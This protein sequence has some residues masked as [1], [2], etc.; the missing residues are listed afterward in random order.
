[1]TAVTSPAAVSSDAAVP[2][3][4]ALEDAVRTVRFLSID[5]VEKAESGHPGAPMGLAGIA[6]EF[7]ARQLNHLP[8]DPQWPN[9]DRFVLSCGHASMLLYS[10]LH[11]S[12]YDV[13]VDDL[14]NFR[15]WGSK[16][17][18][19]PE[20][21]HTPGVETTTGPLGQGIGNAVGLALAQKM[22]SARLGA[23]SSLLDYSV[24][25]VCSDGD[26]MEGVAYE[27]A[28]LAGHLKLDN[29][30]VV[31]DDNRITI[32]GGTEMSFTE[33]VGRRFEGLGWTV[34]AVDGHDPAQVHAAIERAKKADRPALGLA[35]THIGFGSPSKQ[36]K[37][38]SHV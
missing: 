10:M 34:Q 25:A 11:L 14:K 15:Q 7:F 9:R 29:L 8:S 4:A 35:R 17:P 26:L 1:M 13:S 5:A 12:G 33:D 27:A 28:S 20:F 24:F 21:G 2:F 38:P 22:A 6:V 16:T 30:V 32:D 19:H 18:G 36:D 3:D 31:Y 37:S 23:L